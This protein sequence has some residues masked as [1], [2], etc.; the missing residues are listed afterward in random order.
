MKEI[1]ERLENLE[2]YM[3]MEDRVTASD[4]LCRLIRLEQEKIIYKSTTI[5]ALLERIKAFEENYQMLSEKLNNL[6]LYHKKPW[7]CLICDGS[8]YRLTPYD[9]C[10][11]CENT[12]IIWG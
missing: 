3:Q 7:K 5:D 9:V 4:V 6:Q 10:K 12:G 1:E 2:D 8:G 11:T